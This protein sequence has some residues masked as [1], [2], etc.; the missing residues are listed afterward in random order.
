MGFDDSSSDGMLASINVTPLV[1]VML[2][3]LVIF[4]VTAPMIQQG[5][6]LQLPKET[7]APM[8]GKD[9][10]MVVS[11]T[12]DGSVF[13]GKDNQVKIEEL[14]EKIKGIIAGRQ[15]KKVFIK[16]DTNASYGSVMAAMASIRRVGITN[17]GLITEPKA[18]VSSSE[19][20]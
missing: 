14:G 11:V 5:V 18:G 10:Q 17:V 7:I 3:L 20:K 16:A 15:D 19:G 8:E 1:D 9:D 4:M 13:I 12:K 2:V 6:E